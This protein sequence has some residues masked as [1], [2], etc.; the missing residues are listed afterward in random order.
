ML[1]DN[2]KLVEMKNITKTFGKVQAN[3][4]V[5]LT[6]YGGEVHSLLGENGAGKSTLMNILSGIYQPDSGFV[7]V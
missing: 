2:K 6:L 1:Q 7:F 5:F 4:E 3:K